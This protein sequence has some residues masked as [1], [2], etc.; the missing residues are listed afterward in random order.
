MHWVM[1]ATY[2]EPCWTALLTALLWDEDE[3]AGFVL[4]SWWYHE[5]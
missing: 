2:L 4:S 5:K 3:D 1:K